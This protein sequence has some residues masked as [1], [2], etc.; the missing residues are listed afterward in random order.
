MPEAA[1]PATARRDARVACVHEWLT[2]WGG[3]ED[4]FRLILACFPGAQAFA[5]IDHLS[6]ADRQRLAAAGP[7]RTT[8]LQNAPAV[9]RRF[10][11]YLPVTAL[12]VES[13]D[14]GDADIVVSSSHAFAKG[15]LTRADQFHV[16]YVYSPMRYA[17]DLHREYLRD[18]GLD[19]GAKGWLARL[20]FKRLRAWDRQTANNVDLFVAIS[21]H[22]QQ[23][24]WRTYRRPSRLIYP[25]VRV[26]R[27]RMETHKE[28]HYVTVSRLV[29]YKRIDLMLEAFRQMPSRKLVVIGDGPEMPALRR[30]CP[31]NVELRG[32][33]P[34]EAVEAA[35]QSAR[36]FLFAAHEDFGISPVEA[37]ACGTPVIAYGA[38]GS[39]ETLRPL[40]GAA[41]APTGLHFP[42]QTA[43]S[44]AAAVQA[45]EDAGPVFDP[46]ACREFAEGFSEARFQREFRDCVAQGWD[47]WKQDPRALESRL[48]DGPAA[49]PLPFVRGWAQP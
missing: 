9:A 39:L 46:H 19:R 36:A 33:L 1:L 13:H 49:D 3:S 8:F 45:F 42:E 18:Y 6:A 5:T 38:G 47:A 48:C 35:L 26:E 2:E 44:L 21:R 31:P 10:W 43:A 28:D 15:V 29:N 12:A 30:R 14:V 32:R 16:S 23:R 4:A 20:L 34:D 40:G 25:A 41:E 24:I 7:I 17:W 37:Q 22:V 27:L 11:N